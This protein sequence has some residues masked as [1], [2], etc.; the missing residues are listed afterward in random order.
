MQISE[1]LRCLLGAG[2][3]KTILI[4]L[5]LVVTVPH[6]YS[7]CGRTFLGKPGDR[8]ISGDRNN[9]TIYSVGG[10]GRDSTDS[11][12]TRYIWSAGL[13]DSIQKLAYIVTKDQRVFSGT[14]KSFEYYRLCD[15]VGTIWKKYPNSDSTSD[16]ILYDG[17][18]P[19][20]VMG[21]MQLAHRFVRISW[22][23]EAW[24]PI[25]E[26]FV[27]DSFGLVLIRD[28]WHGVESYRLI[29]AYLGGVYY[30]DPRPVS[31]IEQ[32]EA[33]ESIQ[34]VRD[35]TLRLDGM[36][37]EGSVITVLDLRG[38]IVYS[39]KASADCSVDV[40][41]LIKGIYTVSIVSASGRT[42]SN[43]IYIE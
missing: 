19:V 32:Q 40:T 22:F 36:C 23:R 12:G 16:R 21:G 38:L 34:Y 28:L 41:S 10:I 20:D 9:Y 17:L 37:D 30:G 8:Y 42:Q 35:G 5:L 39:G 11:M 14:N 25:D 3:K 18:K 15:T 6:A 27:I 1:Y 4:C 33:A 2:I 24:E 13:K 7:Q 43:L 31:V 29:G 26:E